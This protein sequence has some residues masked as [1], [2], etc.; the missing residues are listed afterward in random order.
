MTYQLTVVNSG[1]IT[2]N[3]VQ[4]DDDMSATFAS[5]ITYM[6]SDNRVSGGECS[7]NA[8]YDGRGDASTGDIGLL[9]GDDT[10]EIAD[11]CEIQIDVT[12]L[13]GSFLGSYDN[14]ATATGTSPG[15]GT[16]DDISQ[17][18]N[19]ADPEGDGP[20]D[21]SVPTP[22]SV[23]ENPEIDVTKTVST[24]PVSNGDGSYSLTYELIVTNVGDILLTDVQVDDDLAATYATAQSFT[25][26]DVRVA[27]GTCR[28]SSTFDGVSDLGL[29]DG[30]SRL[31]VDE[32]CTIEVD[33]TVTP[34]AD[35]GDYLNTA[36]AS[37]ISPAG[38]GVNDADDADVAFVEEPAIGLTKAIIDGPTSNEDGTYAITYEL[39]VTNTGDVPLNDVQ[40]LDD[41]AVTFAEA[42]SFAA[43]DVVVSDGGCT[44]ATDF[45][46]QTQTGLL[47]GTDT[48]AIEASCTIHLDAVVTPGGEL[49]EY[50]NVANALGES[51]GGVPVADSSDSG[52]SFTESPEIGLAKDIVDGPLLVD[53]NT[54]GHDLK[55]GLVVTNTGDVPLFNVQVKDSLQ[56]TFR[57]AD[58]WLLFGVEVTDGD[59]TVSE[60]YDGNGDTD[61][62]TGTDSLN[63]GE[64][65]SIEIFLRVEVGLRGGEFVNSATTQGTSPA[66][67]D[68]TDTSQDGANADPDGQ[69]AGENN[70]P[71]PVGF[72][73]LSAQSVVD[74]DAEPTR[75]TTTTRTTPQRTTTE[76][77]T[78]TERDVP[79][80]GPLA[81][82]GS[83]TQHLVIFGSVLILAGGALVVSTSRRRSE[84]ES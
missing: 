77:E 35:L 33:V 59:C 9:R 26:D 14:T 76:R 70:E 58:G 1:N 44:P 52:A 65:C 20:G 74:D 60:T 6:V 75:T 40:V 32:S 11:S 78:A 82:T 53:I 43:G 81:Y 23:T 55:Y 47:T 13:P 19:D 63:I 51:P 36:D 25:A 41:L 16:V 38:T 10:L 39:V 56:Q 24:E 15:G 2:L 83:N 50:K 3:D 18:G 48:L 22:L 72:A 34:G 79:T 73:S 66:G 61:L 57:T 4:V 64:S 62:L 42:A 69:G 7:A 54:N 8:D 27:D 45:D 30:T 37:G 21:N 49:G 31:L 28:E 67:A 80:R 46:G 5:A 29:L 17:D 12:F 71:T 68:V 84:D